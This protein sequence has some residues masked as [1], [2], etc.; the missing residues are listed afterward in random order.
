DLLIG[1]DGVRSA[2][3][4]F[5]APRSEPEYMGLIGVGGFTPLASLP[6][7]AQKLADTMTFTFGKNGFL[8]YS[9]S[10]QGTMMWW[11]NLFREKEYSREELSQLNASAI[12]Q[13]MLDRFGEYAGLI[14]SLI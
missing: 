8:G 12:V 2:V 6:S 14:P 9:G 4:R 5:V 11:S 10:H 1:A 13:K 7:Y 3:R